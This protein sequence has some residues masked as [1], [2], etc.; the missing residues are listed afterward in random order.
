MIKLAILAVGGQ[1]GGVLTRWIVAVA[2][3]SGYRAQ[4]TSVAGVAQRTGATIYYVEMI[5]QS[6]ELP[7]FALSPSPADVD[8]LIA[9]ELMEAGR[10]VLRGF[11]T[12]Q[13]TTLITS[14]HRILSVAEKSVPG[15][16]QRDSAQVEKSA[17]AAAERYIGFDMEKIAKQHGSVISASLFG[18]L[19]GSGALPFDRADYEAVIRAGGRK[20]DESLRAFS[21][22][23]ER[24]RSGEA[25][26][27]ETPAVPEIKSRPRGP[28]PLVDE[29][30]TLAS[31]AAQL[32]SPVAA[33]AHAGL[34]KVID[35]LD[36]RYGAEYLDLVERALE[37]D[38]A[39]NNFQ[40]STAAAKHLANAMSYDDPIRVAD[41]KIRR[42]RKERIRDEIGAENETAFNITEYFHPRLAELSGC[43]PTGLANWLQNH[44]G[45]YR[46]LDK[47]V[48]RGRR[49]R[50]DRLSGYLQLSCMASLRRFRR[51]LSRH[52]TE[53]QS[54]DKWFQHAMSLVDTNYS[55]A[56]QVLNCR[57]LIKGYSDTHSRG[58]GKFDRLMD[59]VSVVR[60]YP[61]AGERIAELIEIALAQESS[62]PLIE[63][64]M[65]LTN[66]DSHKPNLITYTNLQVLS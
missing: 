58:T 22:A 64:I 60:E 5:P 6:A 3:A 16:G 41:L 2:E 65:Q 38:T 36:T 34:R 14:T 33:I 66:S 11:V 24:T 18:A 51:K 1:G 61:D 50:S 29:W 42:Q 20:A 44:P 62:D 21:A 49:L 43:L 8:V 17:R 28:Q 7:V 56:V 10:A 45:F 53:M 23:F 26:E 4:S 55:L 27:P 59:A 39:G 48:D 15:D 12:P 13:Q 25:D 40:F 30:N 32:P 52:A 63:A 57:R 31:R 35:F 37:K 19:A 9:A 54:R 46:W 47:R